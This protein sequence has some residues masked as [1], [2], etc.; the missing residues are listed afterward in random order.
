MDTVD[1]RVTVVIPTYNRA[2]EAAR[3]VAQLRR[4]PEQPVIIVVDNGSTDGTVQL[5]TDRFPESTVISLDR[6]IGAA[7][8]NVGVRRAA[9][10]YVALCDDDAWWAPG[11]LGRAA[12]LLDAYPRLAVITG[13]VMVGLEERE[14]PT[15]RVMAASPLSFPTP[16][17][18]PPVLGFLA[19]ASMV[20]RSAFL[21]VGGFEAK[22]FLGGEEAMVAADLAAA[23]WALAY[24]EDVTVHHHPSSQREA[25]ARQWLLYRNALWF[26]WL[27]RPLPSAARET[28]RLMKRAS[29]DKRAAQG[30]LRA[31]FG[32]LWVLRRRRVLPAQVEHALRQLEQ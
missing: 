12:D 1:S 29:R 4:L 16:L 20:R 6:N 28:L 15:C 19:G 23:G 8:R 17:P 14:D 32:L 18:G 7:A 21:T 31:T 5:L 30:I 27:R 24:I 10:R 9:T 3:T 22:F 11:A 26:A 25:G 2:A 13:R